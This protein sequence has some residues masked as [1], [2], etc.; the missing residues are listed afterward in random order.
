MLAKLGGYHEKMAVD[1]SHTHT[2]MALM[3]L[4]DSQLMSRL[5]DGLK[6]LGIEADAG[7][8][9]DLRALPKNGS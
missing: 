3:Q 8:A 6:R 2:V 9:I 1:H 4:S 5:Q 7:E